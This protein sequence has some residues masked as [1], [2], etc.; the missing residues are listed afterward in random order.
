MSL[1]LQVNSSGPRNPHD[2]EAW[3]VDRNPVDIRVIAATNKNLMEKVREG[4]F[5]KTSTTD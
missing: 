4:T 5:G 3:V 1:N 2:H